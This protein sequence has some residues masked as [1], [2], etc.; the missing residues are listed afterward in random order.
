MVRDLTPTNPG[1]RPL[2]CN[3]WCMCESGRISFGIPVNHVPKTVVFDLDPKND[4]KR[5][6]GVY[7]LSLLFDILGYAFFRVLRSTLQG[8]KI[9][10]IVCFLQLHETAYP[11][12]TTPT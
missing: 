5:L 8:Y 12:E 1:L 4:G 11:H 7:P 6:V 10:R 9:D 3:L 2:A